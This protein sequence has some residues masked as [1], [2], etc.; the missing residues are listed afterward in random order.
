M[1][2]ALTAAGIVAT[3][4]GTVAIVAISTIPGMRAATNV[5]EHCAAEEYERIAS[6]AFA[7]IVDSDAYAELARAVGDS[8]ALEMVEAAREAMQ[9]EPEAQMPPVRLLAP[10]RVRCPQV[11]AGTTAELLVPF[12]GGTAGVPV[13][14]DTY[15]VAPI[16]GATVKVRVGGTGL[17]PS[18]GLEI[19]PSA[20]DG[21]GTSLDGRN[22]LCVSE[23]DAQDVDVVPGKMQ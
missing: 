2:R 22:G 5:A 6:L 4:L 17:T 1:I 16:V 13:L 7:A 19:G 15:Y 9:Q 21:P 18:L 12:D 11:D 20:R 8:D 14:A 3:F 23:G 10:F